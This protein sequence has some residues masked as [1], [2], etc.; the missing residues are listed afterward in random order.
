MSSS[1]TT[2]A[3]L[4][5]FAARH[6]V[7]LVQEVPASVASAVGLVGLSAWWVLSSRGERVRKFVVGGVKGRLSYMMKKRIA[8]D[9]MAR[10]GREDEEEFVMVEDGGSD[11][12]D[13]QKR[14]GSE[15]ESADSDGWDH[16]LSDDDGTLMNERSGYIK[17][18]EEFEDARDAGEETLEEKVF[19][20]ILSRDSQTAINMLEDGEVQIEATDAYNNTLLMLATQSGAAPVVAYLLDRGINVDAQNWRGQTALHFALAFEYHTLA[21]L[22]LA[23]G[24]RRD[25]RNDYGLL[26]EEGLAGRAL[27]Q[28]YSGEIKSSPVPPLSPG[29]L[30]LPLPIFAASGAPPRSPRTPRGR[31]TPRGEGGAPL[32]T[33]QE[34]AASLKKPSYRWDAS[35]AEERRGGGGVGGGGGGSGSFGRE[36]SGGLLA[37]PRFHD[38]LAWGPK[39][40]NLFKQAEEEGG[41]GEEEE[42]QGPAAPRA[43]SEAGSGATGAGE[44]EGEEDVPIGEI[45]VE[46]AGEE[47]LPQKPRLMPGAGP[48]GAG[49]PPPPPPPPPGSRGPVPPPPPPPPPGSGG[50]PPPP[51]PP[52]GKGAQQGKQEDA[53]KLSKSWEVIQQFRALNRRAVGPVKGGDRKS[54]V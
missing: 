47:A 34:G 3:V 9:N 28:P 11:E 5:G 32:A 1:Q 24:A 18:D 10:S 19:A 16:V 48:G 13:G 23:R 42:Q 46:G 44:G 22:L 53:G 31:R 41:G 50:P 6:G 49:G 12:R 4:G 2:S 36:G 38:A 8:G 20:A 29:G 14:S 33:T 26:P 45:V 40:K 52:G 27:V 21:D 37:S 43:P 51:P 15:R 35:S 30:R 7:Q 17:S 25:I 54:V 39:K